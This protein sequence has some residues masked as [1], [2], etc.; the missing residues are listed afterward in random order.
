MSIK[1]SLKAAMNKLPYVRSLYQSKL[2]LEAEKKEYWDNAYYPPGHFHSPLVAVD[3]IRE[4]ESEIWKTED[5]G[6]IAGIDMHASH[7]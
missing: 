6:D 3:E 5:N 1:N 7:Q 4:R 2:R